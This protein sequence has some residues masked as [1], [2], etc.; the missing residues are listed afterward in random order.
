MN[1]KSTLRF[2][3]VEIAYA[4]KKETVDL[5][6][7]IRPVPPQM[8]VDLIERLRPHIKNKGHLLLEPNQSHTEATHI[9][10]GMVK[11]YVIN[12]R[13]GKKQTLHIWIENDFVVLY[14]YFIN[15][16]PNMI[17]YLEVLEDAELI[18]ISN[19]SME[20]IYNIYPL[21]FELTTIIL[22]G[23]SDRKTRLMLILSTQDKKVRLK[24]LHDLFPE[25]R[26]RLSVEEQCQF[27]GICESTFGRAR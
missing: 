1:R 23:K 24:M 2:L 3:D 27:V 19:I 7:K 16:V 5:L 8:A 20:Y 21:A 15:K 22:S 17:Y 18:S 26:G 14:D 12:P 11:L 10:K 25:Y 13:T 9:R 6:N 4:W